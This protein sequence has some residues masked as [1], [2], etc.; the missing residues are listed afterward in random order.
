MQAMKPMMMQRHPEAGKDFDSIM[1]VINDVAVRRSEELVDLLATVYARN[2]SVDELHD[3][4]AFYHTPTGQK[5][6][7]RQ[8]T[9]ARESM[10]GAQQWAVGLQ[11]ELAQRI[12]QELSKREHAN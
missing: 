10:A 6:I 3:I 5:L 8:P 9:L 7:E 11:A 12:E 1:P 2:F 4:T